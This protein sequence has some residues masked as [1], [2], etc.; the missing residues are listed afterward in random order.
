MQAALADIPPASPGSASSEQ[1]VTAAMAQPGGAEA[2]VQPQASSV[3]AVSQ[4][5]TAQQ[6]APQSGELDFTLPE[7]PDNDG[8]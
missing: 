5:I 2:A 3:G 8:R 4:N 6:A 7:Q 1:P